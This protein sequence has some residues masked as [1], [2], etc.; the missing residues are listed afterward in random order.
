MRNPAG[1]SDNRGAGQG[2]SGLGSRRVVWTAFAFSV[3]L[4]VVVMFVYP[5]VMRR[6]VTDPAPSLLPST[7][8]PSSDMEVI[9]LL[10]IALDEDPQRPEDPED[11]EDVEAPDIAPTGP[12]L[13]ALEGP[14]LVRPGPTAVERLRP[15][16]RDERIWAP[17]AAERVQLSLEQMLDLDM[18]ARILQYQDSVEAAIAAG[19]ALTDWT[20]T[21]SDGK[22][23][24]VSPGKIHLG[25]ITLPLPFNFGTS[26][27]KIQ[28]QRA[29]LA[30]WEAMQR[31]AA[32]AVIQDSWKERAQ[33]IR[34]RRD[35]E[36]S[37]PDTIGRLP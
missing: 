10:E 34:A 35:R 24:G 15:D 37:K 21:D 25:D 8:D 27:H 11:V 13:G 18:A 28:E 22:R 9:A 30:V 19:A 4:H 3:V 17:V 7:A 36:R 5:S 33:A 1:N 32:R 29:L 12:D 2:R 6:D 20:F 26:P 14:V 31:Q 23:W 16:L